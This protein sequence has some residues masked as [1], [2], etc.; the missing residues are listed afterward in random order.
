MGEQSPNVAATE[1]ATKV[2]ERAG[3]PRDQL[4]VQDTPLDGDDDDTLYPS[5]IKLWM[6]V[7]SL[8]V[9]GI[10]TGLDLTIVATAV[11]S[12]SDYFR[13]IEDIGWYSSGFSIVAAS[14]TFLFG[15]LYSLLSAKMLY[16][17]SICIFEIGSLL[18]TVAVTSPMFILGRAVAGVGA[19]G[20]MSGSP[21]LLAYYFPRHRRPLWTTVVV[22]TKMTGIVSAPIVGGALIDW[23]GWRACFGINLPLGVL[24]LV[25]VSFV[26]QKT[27]SNNNPRPWRD[28]LKRFDWFGTISFMPAVTCLLLALQWGGVRYSWADAR[29]IVL[30][31]LFGALLAAFAWRQ[32]QLQDDATLP[33]RIIRMK[34]VLATTWFD[35]C[36]NSSLAVTEY[37]MAIYFQGVKGYSPTYSGILLTPMLVGIIVGNLC[38]GAGIT[39]LGYYNPF[40]F[41]TTILAPIASGLLTTLSLDEN[42]VKVL[43]LLGFLGLAIGF[44]LQA[45]LVALQT[46]MKREDLPMAI[47]A[48]GF[49]GLIGNAVWIV[50][51]TSLFQS[52][53]AAEI[54]LRVPSVDTAQ[55][56]KAGLSQ[57]RDIVGTERLGD[58][59]LGYDEA[60][61]QTLYLPVGLTAATLIGSVF[62]E[63][64]SVKKKKS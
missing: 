10:L 3:R 63:W 50:V 44:G 5:G 12:L 56:E 49:G 39:L 54:A 43:C 58:V 35:A 40:M 7:V 18:C 37:Y 26:K 61:T 6:A 15:K 48:T 9:V 62:T 19:A 42:N 45:P 47:A 17:I 41:M 25:L 16:I 59:L 52:R 2:R 27:T 55:I 64:H 30:F 36:A 53:L 34:T 46:I 38:S 28:E 60:V 33:P 14:F 57:I 29:I 8:C 11:P 51:S 21:V 4:E 23:L 20:I 13:V 24:A 22:S 32:H 31:L 1:Q